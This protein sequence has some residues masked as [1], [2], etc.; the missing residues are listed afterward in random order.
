MPRAN[1]HGV[2]QTQDGV[3]EENRVGRSVMLQ[4]EADA[5]LSDRSYGH[6]DISSILQI[7]FKKYL[8]GQQQQQKGLTILEYLTHKYTGRVRY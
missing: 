1:T 3:R 6:I 2:R 8:L 7:P 4:A 5:R